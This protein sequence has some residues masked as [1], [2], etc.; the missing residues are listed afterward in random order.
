VMA[1]SIQPSEDAGSPEKM[2]LEGR[3]KI[4]DRKRVIVRVHQSDPAT[5]M[6]TDGTAVGRLA[7][8]TE[9]PAV[10]AAQ[11]LVVAVRWVMMGG[12]AGGRPAAVAATR[13][14]AMARRRRRSAHGRAGR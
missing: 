7:R 8:G 11:V 13:R 10:G 3:K 5:I 2:I 9:G 6:G 12:A 1:A 14:R 4:H